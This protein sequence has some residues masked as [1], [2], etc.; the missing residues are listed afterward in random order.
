MTVRVLVAVGAIASGLV[1]TGAGTALAGDTAPQLG[2]VLKRAQQVRDIQ[3]TDAEEQ[4]LGEAVS[5]RIRARYGVVQDPAV[6]KYVSLVGAVLAQASTRP[7]L[8]WRFIVLDTD[9]VN[10]LA[11]PGG[12]VHI[13]RGALSL[14]KSEAELA[15]VLGHEIVHV[16]EKHTI[17]AIQKGKMVQI[18]ADEAVGSSA[19][20]S[21]LV[22][23][24]YEVV[25]A[26]FGREEELESDR[27]GV[28]LA[29]TVGYDP[30]KLGVFLTTLTDRNKASTEKQGL[31]AS[32][33]QMKERL[34]K[35][36]KTIKDGKLTAT[37]TVDARFA[38]FVTYT[39]VPISEIATV[40]AGSAGLA[41]ASK[42]SESAKKDDEQAEKPKKRGFG[43]GRL[44]APSSGGEKAS[45]ETTGS[46]A[47][48]GVD[49]ER[50]AKGGSNPKPV[51]V[52][53]TAADIS[54]FKK[55]GKLN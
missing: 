29:N 33:P 18:G 28:A 38:K 24:A 41:G 1:C 23:K 9:G 20:F 51:L 30:S 12:L 19:V 7:S 55:D 17:K 14:M 21:K 13:T 35:L 15:G 4:K 26:G 37:A 10:A 22:D 52:T 6:H 32:H 2:S 5:E 54:T 45:A 25:D 34:E 50:K 40:E 44:V 49:S 48:R 42:P 43:L 27:K 46:S 3:M 47:A 16:T 8:N 31:F 53:L 36:E 39:P 11:A